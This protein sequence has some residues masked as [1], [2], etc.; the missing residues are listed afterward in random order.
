MN[1]NKTHKKWV[2]GNRAFLWDYDY[3]DTDSYIK[4][5]LPLTLRSKDPTTKKNKCS[6]VSYSEKDAKKLFRFLK[7]IFE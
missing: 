7:N 4:R 6:W 3:G 2:D 5:K 1:K